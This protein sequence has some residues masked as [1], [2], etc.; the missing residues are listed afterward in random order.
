MA[1]GGPLATPANA[2]R[3]ARGAAIEIQTQWTE[4]K[5]ETTSRIN[6]SSW[7]HT[8]R[9]ACRASFAH[10]LAGPRQEQ[11]PL[12]HEPGGRQPL[13]RVP[14]I[15][16]HQH[17]HQHQLKWQHR[18]WLCRFKCTLGGR[19]ANQQQHK[20]LNWPRRS[21]CGLLIESSFV[22]TPTVAVGVVL[23]AN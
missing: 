22:R 11:S 15:G 23:F 9:L 20:C 16:W 12:G 19:A 13:S 14:P 5:T 8:N 6:S 10:R 1:D 21:N 17:Q 2:A 7:P 3:A 4:Y 18:Q